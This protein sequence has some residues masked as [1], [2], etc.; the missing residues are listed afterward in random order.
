MI[1][2]PPGIGP[3]GARMN[4]PRVPSIGAPI[5]AGYAPGIRGPPPPGTLIASNRPN[6]AVELSARWLIV[7]FICTGG[8]GMPPGMAMATGGRPQWQP[9][10]STPMNYSSSSPGNYGVSWSHKCG[11]WILCILARDT[12][13]KRNS[14]FRIIRCVRML[15]ICS[16]NCRARPAEVLPVQEHL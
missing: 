4:P 8:P 16:L 12:F 15:M 2:G 11:R 7:L 10:T 13:S 1:G 9:N 14:T 6:W 3:M 5:P